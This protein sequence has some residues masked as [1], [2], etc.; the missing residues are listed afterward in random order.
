M[1]HSGKTAADRCSVSHHYTTSTCTCTLTHNTGVTLCRFRSNRLTQTLFANLQIRCEDTQVA[2]YL[3]EPQVRA[4]HPVQHPVHITPAA[5]GAAGP[6]RS[7]V[8][9]ALHPHGAV[10]RSCSALHRGRGGAP[11]LQ[12]GRGA[13]EASRE[14][15]K[16]GQKRHKPRHVLGCLSPQGKSFAR[17]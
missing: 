4:V 2:R 14:E 12:L 13:P 11:H 9:G 7:P 17:K 5:A 10:H 15:R 3:P 6:P 8:Q 16:G 1:T